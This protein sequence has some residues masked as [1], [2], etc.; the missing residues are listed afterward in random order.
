MNFDCIV[1][2]FVAC[3]PMTKLSMS[4]T[5]KQVYSMSRIHINDITTAIRNRDIFS[6]INTE[7]WYEY[8]NSY[9]IGYLGSK[10][11]EAI[12]EEYRPLN[13]DQVSL[14]ACE[15][16]HI[17]M[18]YDG[19]D[20]YQGFE[21]ACIHD[22]ETAKHIAA[23]KGI[24]DLRSACRSGDMD[25]VKMCMSCDRWNI[26]V[27]ACL[28]R[29]LDIV[30]L[31]FDRCQDKSNF[32]WA[33][34]RS[35]NFDIFDFVRSRVPMTD[36]RLF[37]NAC[38]GGNLMIIESLSGPMGSGFNAACETGRLDI[39]K[40]L[41]EKNT[42]Q[43]THEGGISDFD[44]NIGNILDPRATDG[45]NNWPIGI[46]TATIH[47]HLHIVKFL[48]AE[49]G[50]SY[51]SLSDSCSS[52]NLDMVKYAIECG[53]SDWDEGLEASIYSDD[54]R[55]TQLM[56][57]NARNYDEVLH[58]ACASENMAAVKMLIAHG[59]R[60]WNSGFAGAS[61]NLEMMSLMKSLSESGICRDCY[62][63]VSDHK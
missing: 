44:L 43:Y 29:N 32:L 38:I 62:T 31:V 33:A 52:G 19:F 17:H 18:L 25:L 2:I 7:N 27:E 59:A 30:K 50:T 48:A 23:T 54:I 42:N 49:I 21:L 58:D 16:G 20:Y 37:Y 51:I 40:I 35:G 1:N 46:V 8:L 4:L 61:G 13:F 60:D 15:G 10:F 39:L 63:P 24:T 41:I 26:A 12:Y 6:I 9:K 45:P 3:E 11:L 55:I 56:I 47:G 14:G 28:G 36:D 34:C 5:N 53:A 22:V 57:K